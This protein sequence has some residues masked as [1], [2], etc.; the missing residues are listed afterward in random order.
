MTIEELRKEADKLGYRICKKPK[1]IILE[2]C[3]CGHVMSESGDICG[4]M[5]GMMYKCPVCNTKPDHFSQSLNN[6]KNA[7]NIEMRRRK[8]HELHEDN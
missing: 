3:I 4:G 2:N 1:K 6:A 7:W 8:S 5:Y